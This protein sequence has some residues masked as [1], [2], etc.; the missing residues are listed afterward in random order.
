MSKN[1]RLIILLSTLLAVIMIALIIIW[2]KLVLTP[3]SYECTNFA[4][5]TYIQQTVYGS[6]RVEAATA[7]AKDI[8]TL[9]DLISW[10]DGDSD[11]SKLNQAAGSDWV[12]LDAKTI[13]ILKTSLDVAEKSD[14]AFDPTI[15]PIST[16]WNFGGE[17]QQVPA[18]DDLKKYIQFV[19]YKDLRID[20]KESTASLKL[21]YMAVDLSAIGE[22]AA[23]DEAVAAYR[24]AGADSG[25]IAVGGSVGVYGAKSEK[26]PWRVAVRDPNS[27]EA[28]STSM[29]EIELSSGFVSTSGSYDHAFTKDGVTYHHLL[30]PKSGYPE[31]NGLVST[32]VVC[33]SGALSDALSTAC[34]ILGKEKGMELLKKYNAEGIF[35]DKNDRVY[36][37]ENLM[38]NFKI[39]NARYNL[40][41]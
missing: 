31:N 8:G 6:K 21:H 13:S 32:T 37:T 18:P 3:Q 19:N 14:G 36:V 29:G 15:L 33:D 4:M 23:C 5:G 22:G 28:Q 35:I 12:S 11:I 40:V 27:K 1:K 30:D 24:N 41:K 7:A 10:R 2:S 34:F 16:L 38:N 26:S 17:N 25:I 20:T 39:T 9:D